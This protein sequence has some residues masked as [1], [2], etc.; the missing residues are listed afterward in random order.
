MDLDQ[1]DDI[2]EHQITARNVVD[3]STPK[4]TEGVRRLRVSKIKSSP[5]PGLIQKRDD[6]DITAKPEVHG[7]IGIT[8]TQQSPLRPQ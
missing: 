3:M 5:G 8:L 1:E 7:H 2:D 6:I 4:I